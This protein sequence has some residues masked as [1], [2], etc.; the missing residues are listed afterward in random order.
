MAPQS[1]NAGPGSLSFFG[2]PHSDDD[3]FHLTLV[4]T[5]IVLIAWAML[6]LLPR[7][8]YTVPIV[9]AVALGF[10]ALYVLL[11]IDG[12]VGPSKIDWSAVSKGKYATPF[13]MFMSLDGV[14]TLFSQKSAVFGGWI[15]YVV[16][17]LWVGIWVAQNAVEIGFPQLLTAPL[18]FAIM[19]LGP[20]GLL[21]YFLLSSV[22]VLVGPALGVV[23]PAAAGT[24]GGGSAPKSLEA[25]GK[26]PPLL[27][28][29]SP[30]P[31]PTPPIKNK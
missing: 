23:P 13:D 2:I 14:H 25:L 22:F 20:S 11:L 26:T 9:K 6:A 17:D 1:T 8:K 28:S 18:L 5:P 12:M 10:A 19:M 21:L 16:F 31:T 24:A 29:L 27:L 7:W 3:L 30:P 15:H 4:K